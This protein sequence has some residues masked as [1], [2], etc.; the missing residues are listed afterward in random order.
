M[1]LAELALPS[2]SEAC[3]E[4]SKIKIHNW[5]ENRRTKNNEQKFRKYVE[6]FTVAQKIDV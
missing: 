6:G 3:M 1:F 2:P 4:D 5:K